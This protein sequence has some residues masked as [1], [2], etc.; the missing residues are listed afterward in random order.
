MLILKGLLWML[1]ALL[2]IGALCWVCLWMQKKAPSE[3]YDERQKIEQGKASNIS[4][5]TGLIYFIVVMCG[6]YLGEMQVDTVFLIFTGL[7]LELMVYHVYCLMTHAALPLSRKPGTTI[8]V[9][10]INGVVW[11]LQAAMYDPSWGMGLEGSGSRF[12]MRVMTSF[13]GFS[14]AAMHLFSHLRDKKE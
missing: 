6:M 3:E 4:N 12:W 13:C 14:L 9:Y 11:A 8:S 10:V 1:A 7:I 5:M 2:G